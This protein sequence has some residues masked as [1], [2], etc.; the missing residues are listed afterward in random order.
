MTRFD[1]PEAQASVCVELL[2]DLDVPT[3]EQYSP[4]TQLKC[5]NCSASDRIDQIKRSRWVLARAAANQLQLDELDCLQ[6]LVETSKGPT[7]ASFQLQSSIAH[8]RAPD[9][10]IV[11]A[12]A[13]SP[14]RI[15]VD[16]ER[17][18]P[19]RARAEIAKRVFSNDEFAWMM[20]H[21]ELVTSRFFAIWTLREAALKAGH[22]QLISAP[23]QI[24]EADAFDPSFPYFLQ[25]YEGFCVAAVLNPR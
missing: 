8:S 18:N 11:C 13:C 24:I 19:N 25:F 6:A 7:F 14:H 23:L 2:S 1:W 9:Q 12:A 21:S 17:L 20:A 15:G 5:E 10:R 3:F 22:I 16:L 4:Q